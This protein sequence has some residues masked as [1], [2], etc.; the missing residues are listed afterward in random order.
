MEDGGIRFLVRIIA[1]LVRRDQDR[2]LTPKKQ[3]NPFLPYDEDLFVSDI[4]DTHVCLLNKFNVLDYHLLIVTRSFEDQESLLS[5]RDF[6]AT[7][8]CLMEFEGLAFYNAGKRAGASQRHKHLQ[9]VPL[10]LVRLGPKI[11]IEPLFKSA[12][13]RGSIGTLPGLPFLHAIV[14]V[15]PVRSRSP[16]K[17][18]QDTLES[19]H[20][21]LEA[22]GLHCSYS[23]DGTGRCDPYNLLMTREWMLL[24]P[25]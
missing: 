10:P 18:A 17:D 23:G 12:R 20:T 6:M 16:L 19:Y 22:M 11:H 7:W 8:A 15:D 25:R 14:W 4:S 1:N 24:V 13:F 21:M 5:L 3:V 2:E 9:I